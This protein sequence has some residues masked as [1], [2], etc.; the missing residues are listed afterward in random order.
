MILRLTHPLIIPQL[1]D[2]AKVV[3]GTPIE[4]MKRLLV[5]AVYDENSRVFVDKQDGVVKGFIYGSIERRE[6]EPVVYVQFC[7]VLPTERYTCPEL[8]SRMEAWARERKIKNIVFVTR[9]NWRAY[10]RK[11]R[12]SF[13]GTILKRSVKYE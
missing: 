6:G 13:D 12:F 1:V 5:G 9:R 11:Y 7:V 10:A 2:M 3:P 8:L 4:V